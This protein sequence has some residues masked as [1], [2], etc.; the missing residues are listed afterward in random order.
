MVA[1]IPFISICIPTYNRDYLLRDA[2]QSALNQS[3][4]NYEII[5]IDDGSTDNT[6]D[7]VGEFSSKRIKYFYKEHSGMAS[8]HNMFVEKVSGEYILKLD[9]DD[10]LYPTVLSV[11]ANIILENDVDFIYCFLEG[12]NIK[13]KK[14][15]I[16]RYK[17]FHRNEKYILGN[18][19]NGRIISSPCNLVKK[20]S[21][22]DVGGY[23]EEYSV[24]SDYE[25]S[26]K[27]FEKAK[28]FGVQKHLYR[29]GIHANNTMTYKEYPNFSEISEINKRIYETKS[30]MAI[31]PSFDKNNLNKSV[32]EFCI[33]WQGRD[34]NDKALY[35]CAKSFFYWNDFYTCLEVL[36]KIPYNKFGYTAKLFIKSCIGIGQYD[37]SIC[38]AKVFYVKTNNNFY[39]LM[40]Q[41][42]TKL[43][44]IDT[45]LQKNIELNFEQANF[46]SQIKNSLGFYPSTYFF[47][48]ANIESDAKEKYKYF[49]K[50]SITNPETVFKAP[51]R[52][53]K[54]ITSEVQKNELNLSVKRILRPI[55]F[56][57]ERN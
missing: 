16:N 22:I 34:A 26:L 8:T 44:D 25:L 3:Y 45:S 55:D 19:M 49:L 50:F 31:F 30:L 57:N 12:Y 7:V 24:F 42:A 29:Y 46:L 6:R 1:K 51:L 39:L 33:N 4:D 17:N 9:D 43:R 15:E 53:E 54:Y 27:L 47:Y 18:M 48:K 13:T 20:N 56:Y 10:M 28:V 35:F 36:K 14:K 40:T 11:Y 32:Q 21:V 52:F 23:N 2:I 5:I 41:I 37:D 38:L